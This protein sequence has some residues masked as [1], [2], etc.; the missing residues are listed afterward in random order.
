MHVEEGDEEEG[1]EEEEEEE[2]EEMNLESGS[3]YKLVI[4]S[5]RQGHY[6]Q[7]CLFSSTPYRFY[8]NEEGSVKIFN[9]LE[10]NSS[11][12]IRLLLK[13]LTLKIFK[14]I[15][16]PIFKYFNGFLG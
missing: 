12:K 16:K 2:E 6:R 15:P 5:Q 7:V 13:C 9:E 4:S 11:K 14:K 1:E 10:N 8:S 3:N